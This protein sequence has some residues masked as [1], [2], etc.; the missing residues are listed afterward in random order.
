[1]VKTNKLQLVLRNAFQRTDAL[2]Y[3]NMAVSVSSNELSIRL[4][5]R[6]QYYGALNTLH[7]CEK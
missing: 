5:C 7:Q 6:Y 3:D 1:M 2:I 4:T